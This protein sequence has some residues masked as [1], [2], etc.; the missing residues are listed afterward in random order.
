M[1]PLTREMSEKIHTECLSVDND[2]VFVSYADG[3]IRTATKEFY[4]RYKDSIWAAKLFKPLAFGSLTPGQRL[5]VT[6][7]HGGLPVKIE[8]KV[9][10]HWEIIYEIDE[11]PEGI[12]CLAGC[13]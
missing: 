12:T 5:R 9:K 13:Y 4:R 8:A 3:V 1:V 2:R 7:W 10:R 6:N 11:L